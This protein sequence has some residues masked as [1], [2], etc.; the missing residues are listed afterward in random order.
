MNLYPMI[1]SNFA[2]CSKIHVVSY[3][4]DGLILMNAVFVLY[5][6]L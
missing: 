5:M 6:T 3:K 4:M 1:Q 2:A